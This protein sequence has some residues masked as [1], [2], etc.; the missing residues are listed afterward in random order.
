[1]LEKK[2]EVNDHPPRNKINPALLPWKT[3][4][5]DHPRSIIS[6]NFDKNGRLMI[7]FD[8]GE[9]IVTDPVPVSETIQNYISVTQSSDSGVGPIV[10]GGTF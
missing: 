7:V 1:L 3:L 10:D 8:D 5:T 2:L 9:K 6:A 4:D